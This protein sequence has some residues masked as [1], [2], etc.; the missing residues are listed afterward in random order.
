MPRIELDPDFRLQVESVQENISLP[1]TIKGVVAQL[2]K[3]LDDHRCFVPPAKN[4]KAARAN[5]RVRS[6]S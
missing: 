4:R 6:G 3:T 2:V 1:P 5:A